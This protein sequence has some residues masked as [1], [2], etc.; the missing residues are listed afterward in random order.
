MSSP[1]SQCP[2]PTIALSARW[3]AYPRR[4][5]C[6]AAHGFALEYTPS[7]DALE[8]LPTH[9]AAF[10]AAGIPV[11]YH[12][13]FPEHEFGH[14]DA[15][16]AETSLRLQM[17]L[18]EAMQGLGDQVIT[19]HIGLLPTTP[20]DL[21]RAQANLVRL[22]ERAR[23]LGIT[24][25]LENLRRGP[26]SDPQTVRAWAQQA[27]TMITLDVGH[28]VSCQ[29]VQRGERT[30]MDYIATFAARLLEVH[31]YEREEDRHYPPKDMSI[32]GPI[33]ERLL[34]TR[35]SWWTLELPT[36]DEALATRELLLTYLE[37]R[38]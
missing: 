4:F 21:G 14:R 1:D 7:P 5:R 16:I 26:T 2:R 8:A 34:E 36:L 10:L 38:G 30:V 6:L 25:C 22:A 18:L 23:E 11:R 19:V 13:F 29:A 32:L 27:D 20:L 9:V 37:E 3:N 28:A 24:L 15:N 17:A 35:C 31:L 33:V 12:A